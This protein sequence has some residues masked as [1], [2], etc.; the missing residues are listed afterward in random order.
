MSF[1]PVQAALQGFNFLRERPQSVTLWM[2]AILMLSLATAAFRASP[3][4]APL[5]ELRDLTSIQ[6][7]DLQAVLALAPRLAPSA[8]LS[9]FLSLAGLCVI[10]PSM[11]RAQLR[12]DGKT[13]LRLGMDEARM[14]GLFM[15]VV[16]ITFVA[17]VLLGVV[18]GI[19][20]GVTAD[21]GIAPVF[22]ALA[23]ISTFLLPVF[24]G[25]RLCLGAPL[26]LDTH[27][28]DLRASWKLTR[29]IFW[30]LVAGLLLACL[31]CLLVWVAATLLVMSVLA[32]I[33]LVGGQGWDAVTGWLL[34]A[35][36]SLA[37][38]FAPGPLVR[39]LIDSALSAVLGCILAGVLVHAY[40]HRQAVLAK[41]EAADPTPSEA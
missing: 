11:I 25:I 28:L 26:A 1:S 13:V 41:P 5:G 6:P 27:H 33:A 29:G 30:R 4:A 39:E 37:E 9:V 21:L 3:W 17:A 12:E 22:I 40:R 7:I 31:L 24:V 16:G 23:G 35:G 10:F 18:F 34:P 20:A 36:P 32:V 2:A 38:Q 14:F 19:L 8:V 15:A